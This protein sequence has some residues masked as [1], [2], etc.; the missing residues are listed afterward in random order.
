MKLKSTLTGLGLLLCGSAMQGAVPA[1]NVSDLSLG[2]APQ[3]MKAD[4][5]VK[6]ILSAAP[7]APGEELP[8]FITSVP[9]TAEKVLYSRDWHGFFVL[10]YLIS[11]IIQGEEN[12]RVQYLYFDGDDVY[13]PTPVLSFEAPSYIKGT[14]TETGISFPLPQ[15]VYSYYDTEDGERVR[16]D[17]YVDFLYW[18][19]DFLN[20]YTADSA[21]EHSLDLVL[22]E[23][24][25][26]HWVNDEIV[27][28]EVDGETKRFMYRVFGIVNQDEAWSGYADMEMDMTRWT[29][30]AVT[31]APAGGRT[32]IMTLTSG[33]DSRRVNVS[34]TGE[35]EIWVQGF[36]AQNPSSWV[37]GKIDGDRVTF[38]PQYVGIDADQE[39]FGTFTGATSEMVWSDI[40]EQEQLVVTPKE[41]ATFK[42]DA[43]SYNLTCIDDCMV[44]GGAEHEMLIEFIP[45]PILQGQPDTMIPHTPEIE[46][47]YNYN[48]DFGMGRVTFIAPPISD[49][50]SQL[51][52][53][54]LSWSIEIDGEL[55]LWDPSKHSRIPEAMEWVPYE[56][57]DNNDIKIEAGDKRLAYFKKNVVDYL[58]VRVRSLTPDGAYLRSW[59]ALATTDHF[60]KED[61]PNLDDYPE[62]CENIL[63]PGDE[64][65]A[66]Y[67]DL[68]GRRLSGAPAKGMFIRVSV[69]ADGL[70]TP[71]KLAK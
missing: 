54:L 26:Y 43:D 53:A 8:Y 44:G 50:G 1:M 2:A 42:Y 55:Y 16:K 19:M 17:F 24:G 71:M 57:T 69:S 14:K 46:S 70:R 23:D 41:N 64:V 7:Q 56:F 36:S 25:T 65:S 18:D 52:P 39:Y 33:E 32:T 3:R 48:P 47:W 13:F 62:G 49:T 20:Y 9:S 40:L 67:Y 29:K 63:L 27:S 37:M 45:Y 59:Y 35:D 30:E 61:W 10:N 21:E 5:S 66:E 22:G 58:A 12:E 60:N 68:S 6:N 28:G 38:E 51:D 31:E 4:K 11:M 15:C 34:F